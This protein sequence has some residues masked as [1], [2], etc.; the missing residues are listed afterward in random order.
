[1]TENVNRATNRAELQALHTTAGFGSALKKVRLATRLSIRAM[2]DKA[3]T[4][5]RNGAAT[6]VDLTKNI[7]ESMEKG[8][9]LG[10]RPAH[11]LDNR[12][13]IYLWCCN[14][15]REDLP[16]WL[17]ARRRILNEPAPPGPDTGALEPGPAVRT[18]L[19][20]DVSLIGRDREVE[21][22]LD[23][24]ASGAAV[25]TING[26]PGVG[27][28][29][30]AIR[31]AHQL[32]SRYPDGRYF[33]ELH[34]HTPGR[35]VADPAD[36]LAGLLASIGVESHYLPDSLGARR[37]LWQDRL[38]G[39]R[40]LLVLDDARDEAQIDPLLPATPGSLALVTSRRRLL[41]LGDAVPLA[42]D[43]LEHGSAVEL[44][45]TVSHRSLSDTT[46]RDAVER[47]VRLCGHLP[48]AI[49]LLAGPLAH[50]PAWTITDLA[51]EFD[52][53]T[54]RLG[55]PDERTTAIRAAFDL[56][57]RELPAE[58]ARLFR[59]LGL[60]HG[61][62]L[63][64]HA[65]AALADVDVSTART[66]LES[67]YTDHLLDESA[68]GRFRLH[69]LLKEYARALVRSE[70]ETEQV[71]AQNRLLDYYHHSAAAADRWITRRTHPA[72]VRESDCG[73]GVASREFG[74]EVAALAWMRVERDNLMAC[75]DSLA[76]RE[77][78]RMIT[79][80]AL[81][82]GLLDRDGP[83]PLACR[84][85]RRAVAAAHELDDS[86]QEAGSL[87]NL[88]AALWRAGNYSAATSRFDTARALYQRDNNVLGEANSL[89]NLG[90]VC[91]EAG[92]YRSA[93][94]YYEQALIQYRRCGDTLG[95]ANALNNL[96]NAWEA[97]GDYPTAIDQ[98]EQALTLYDQLDF[99]LGK[100]NSLNNIGIVRGRTGHSTEAV[101]L[102]GL[103][104]QLYRQLGNRLG[105]ANALTNLGIVHG[106]TASFRDAIALH[107]QALELYREL[108]SVRGEASVLNNLGNVRTQTGLY[109]EASVLHKQALALS[110]R[111]GH[112][113]GEANALHNLGVVCTCTGELG[114]A[115][116]LHQ[117][118]CELYRQLGN[119]FDQIDI[120]IDLGRLLL[121]TAVPA[122]AEPLFDEALT[123]AQQTDSPIGQARALDGTVRCR[124]RATGMVAFEEFTRAIELY[125]RIGTP[126][127]CAAATDLTGLTSAGGD[128]PPPP[129]DLDG[130]S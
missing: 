26:M 48:L 69:D 65:A 71:C 125:H 74:D 111:L 94:T 91:E 28:T 97:T 47:L 118:A 77:Q 37:D 35:A 44:F 30:L 80:T 51:A 104:L 84:L 127:A 19:R 73:A 18:A 62:D 81:L 29:A 122:D 121:D 103:A 56:S 102:H 106:R 7:I 36:V 16:A 82:A 115:V 49:T 9:R 42:L 110:R 43:T 87:N 119:R 75:L 38:V 17:E 55:E 4:R 66:Q 34:A 14:V 86:L 70:P 105:E 123:L 27:K 112:R 59:R 41:E 130:R 113:A 99:R 53:T 116:E 117:Q 96:G 22:I 60:H 109:E 108:G 114:Q 15:P 98:F 20:R 83:W 129:G 89:N 78:V 63:D 23:R 40:I 88:G 101:E 46:D 120:L 85:H 8:Q 12:L 72:S 93:L 124:L 21:R 58:R 128:D 39:K 92:D 13:E 90:N 50:H 25:H 32:A 1:M 76:Q 54:D 95:E 100:A 68:R 24:A 2:V 31:A 57:Y 10:G 61:A 52:A 79:M 45:A 3:A 5:K 6:F 67:L 11:E 33:V 107:H 64:A 126:D